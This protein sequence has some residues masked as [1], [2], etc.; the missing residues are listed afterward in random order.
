[1]VKLPAE[2]IKEVLIALGV[3]NEIAIQMIGLLKNADAGTEHQSISKERRIINTVR[4]KKEAWNGNEDQANE[5]IIQLLAEFG[6]PTNLKGYIYLRYAIYLIVTKYSINYNIL[7]NI[8]YPEIAEEF[9]TTSNRI[10]RAI[11]NAITATW[12]RGNIELLNQYFENS[13]KP[14]VVIPS[15]NRF[16]IKIAQLI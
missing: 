9:Q 2:Q 15:N 6:V 4:A 13:T 3:E 7:Q 16:I 12:N 10:R 14:E 1:M 11:R 8:V 5:K